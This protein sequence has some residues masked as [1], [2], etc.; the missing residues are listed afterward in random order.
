[1]SGYVV[2]VYLPVHKI[3]ITP[4]AINYIERGNDMKTFVIIFDIR[5]ITPGHVIAAIII[6]R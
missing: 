3:K 4:V 6:I 2:I 1:M 5:W